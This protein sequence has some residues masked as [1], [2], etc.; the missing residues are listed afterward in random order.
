MIQNA[1]PL[2]MY[3]S[4]DPV[5]LKKHRGRVAINIIDY[6]KFMVVKLGCL[7]EAQVACFLLIVFLKKKTPKPVSQIISLSAAQRV[8]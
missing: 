7:C 5:A 2:N 6:P 3:T 8:N 1:V 4:Q